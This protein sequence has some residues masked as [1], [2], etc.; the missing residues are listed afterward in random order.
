MGFFRTK[1]LF[2]DE[3]DLPKGEWLI[4]LKWVYAYKKNA[5]GVNILEKARVVAQGFNQ[6]PG[7]FDETYAPVAKMASVCVLLTW[8]AVHDLKIFQFDCK[9]AFLHAKLRH[10]NYARQFPGYAFMN[11]DKV[12]HIKVALYGLRQLAFEFYT[13]FMSLILDLGMV[14]CEVDHGIF[15]GEWLSPPD[16]LVIPYACMLLFMLMM[17]LQ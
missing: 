10:P 11:P 2:P 16:A 6:R 8:A 7:Q 14:R 12:L 3:V 4:G 1:T 9:T 15:F 13:L 5:E 17:V